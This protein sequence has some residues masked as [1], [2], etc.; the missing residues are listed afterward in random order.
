MDKQEP[1]ATGTGGTTPP[2]AISQEFVEVLRFGECFPRRVPDPPVN[3]A[4]VWAEA[5]ARRRDDAQQG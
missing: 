1:D 5:R 2:L 3:L 4:A